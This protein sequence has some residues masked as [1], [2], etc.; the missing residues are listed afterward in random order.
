MDPLTTTARVLLVDDNE[1]V[2]SLM[3]DFL[4][5]G[6]QVD[7][8]STAGQALKAIA[9]NMPDVIL[10]DVNMPG[11]DGLTLLQSLR[12]HGVTAPAFVITGYDAPGQAARAQQLGATK[13]MVKPIDLRELDREI[14][15]T[16]KT[17]RLTK[18]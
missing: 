7:R 1:T 4:S 3:T 16:L 14:A 11:T 17:K 18:D 2:L 6:Y 9:A 5:S 15:E 12:R 8:A 13:Y 10:L